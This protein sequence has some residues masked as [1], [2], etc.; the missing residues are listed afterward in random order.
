MLQ[1]EAINGLIGLHRRIPRG[2]PNRDNCRLRMLLI[3][4]ALSHDEHPTSHL[5]SEEPAL[6]HAMCQIPE[7][8][9][10]TTPA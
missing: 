9:P 2:F 6:G 7:C 8:P 3:G 5:T 4:G 10:E 1:A